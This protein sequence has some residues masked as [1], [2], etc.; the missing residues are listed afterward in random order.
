MATEAVNFTVKGGV[1]SATLTWS[2]SETTNLLAWLVEQKI[3]EAGTWVKLPQLEASKREE[4]YKLAPGEVF[5]RVWAIVKQ[6]AKEAKATVQPQPVAT[7]KLALTADKTGVQ[8]LSSP[9]LVDFALCETSAGANPLYEPKGVKV[10]EIVKGKAGHEWI[11]AHVQGQTEWWS[12]NNGRIKVEVAKVEPP[13]EEPKHEEPPVEEPKPSGFKRGICA[14]GWTRS[15]EVTDAKKCGENPVVRLENPGETVAFSKA[16]VAV[17]YLNSGGT[18]TALPHFADEAREHRSRVLEGRIEGHLLN[19]LL[20]SLGYSTG[21]VKSLSASAVA[22]DAVAVV[23]KHPDIWAYEYLNEPGGSWF[24]GS[25]AE[26]Q[27]NAA[28]YCKQLKAIHEA[29]VKEFGT[30]RPL[31]V[32]SFDGGHAGENGWGKRMLAA[33]KEVVNYVDAFTNHPY[34]G[35][36]A[37]P[38]STLVHWGSVEETHKLTGKPII[39]SEY[40]RPLMASTGDSPKSTETQQAKA[41]AAMVKRAKESGFCLGVTIYGYRGNSSPCYAVFAENDTPRPAVPAIAAA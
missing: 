15:T 7:L 3:G 25:G 40:G 26:S 38:E 12:K 29:F 41:D 39:I 18:S 34:D 2:A 1:E 28:A 37:N 14:G 36:S 23:K 32:A 5:F 24:W 21:G 35:G 16:G 27:E 17:I 20:G 8:V 31:L 19:Q 13:V 30:K 22:A 10:G 33:D 9:G 4:T 11:D 6:N